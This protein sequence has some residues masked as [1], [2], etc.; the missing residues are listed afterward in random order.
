M[1]PDHA[2]PT[3]AEVRQLMDDWASALRARDVDRLL[4][5]YAPGAVFF[6]AIGPLQ[7]DAGP[8][9]KNWDEFF[10]WFPGPVKVETRNLKISAGE[11]LAFARLL[12]R[13]VGTTAEGKEEGAWMRETIG[14]EKAGASWRI[15]HEHWSMSMDMKTG[16]AAH[17]LKPE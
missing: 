3:E 1:Q 2:H 14:F 5:F 12:V 9:R 11:S 4:S 16:K 15:T 8:F 7:M 10:Q 6:D 13:L 17:D